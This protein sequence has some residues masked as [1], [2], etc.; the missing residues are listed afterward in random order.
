MADVDPDNREP[1]SRRSRSGLDA[2]HALF[3]AFPLAYFVL[4]F[5][6][7]IAYSRSYNLQWQYFSIWLIVA[8][9]VMG[10]FAIL[11]GAID[12]LSGRRRAAERPRG[13]LWHILLPVIAWLLALLN[14]FVHSRDG[15][16]AVVPEG[17]ILSGIV[18]LL[19]IAGA[20]LSTLSWWRD[21]R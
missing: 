20:I 4:A 9:L 8:G 12:W 10:G 19:M 3:G 18:A 1:V 11:F 15:W 13:S 14:A 2:L 21:A 7:D 6:T 5:L 16:T 17:I